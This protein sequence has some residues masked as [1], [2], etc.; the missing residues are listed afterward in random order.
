[1]CNVTQFF[2]ND[3]QVRLNAPKFNPELRSSSHISP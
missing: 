2:L 1:L 3:R